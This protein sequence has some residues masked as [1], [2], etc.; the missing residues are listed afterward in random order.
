MTEP[1]NVE[2]TQVRYA[3]Q[4]AVFIHLKNSIF[5]LYDSILLIP[6]AKT[7]SQLTKH[8]ETDF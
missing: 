8:Q 3:I 4:F 2:I 7:F 6:K 1:T 5:H